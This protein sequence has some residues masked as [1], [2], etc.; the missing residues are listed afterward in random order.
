MHKFLVILAAGVLFL[1]GNAQA[2]PPENAKLKNIV[3]TAR[4]AG[5]FTT[6]LAAI[7]AADLVGTL[8][9]QGKGTFTV[10]APT[11]EA[12]AKLPAGTVE[13][14]LED[15]AALRKILLYHVASGELPASA[16][17]SQSSIQTLEGGSLSVSTAGGVKVNDATVT[18]TDIRARNGII[19]VID[20]VLIPQ[21]ASASTGNQ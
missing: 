3:Q 10:F 18:A 8:S 6:L 13:S 21:P 7:E 20:T 5:S 19:H 9:G 15:P 14:L 1:S 2:S 12:F 11:D 16:V 17:V 4:Q